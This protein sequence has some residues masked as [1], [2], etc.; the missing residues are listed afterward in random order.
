MLCVALQLSTAPAFRCRQGE[1]VEYP[2]DKPDKTGSVHRVRKPIHI[3]ST[4]MPQPSSQRY[5][6]LHLVSDATGETL[7]TV[8]KAAAAQYSDFR[9]IA[10]IY[11]LV[12]NTL[13]A[14]PCAAGNRGAARNRALHAH[15]SRYP[16]ASR[17]TMRSDGCALPFHSRSHHRDTVAVSQCHRRGPR[18]GAS[19]PS[20]PTI[21][22]ASTH[23]TS[24]WL[25]TMGRAPRISKNPMS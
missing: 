17:G 7:N 10:H 5:F 16:Q 15:Q 13:A 22:A 25:M 18:S 11:A 12:Q 1:A 2:E 8:A 3:S 9:P 4:A 6:H 19:T 14:E 21:S 23:S 20:T 24:L